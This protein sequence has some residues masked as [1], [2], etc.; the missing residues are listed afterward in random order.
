MIPN[1]SMKNGRLTK[2]P[3][4][5]GSLGFQVMNIP[6]SHH[7][8]FL[9]TPFNERLANPSTPWQGTKRFPTGAIQNSLWATRVRMSY[10]GHFK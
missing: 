2:H 7:G 5:N 6:I 4:Q 10:N 9:K 8:F 1:L 3:L